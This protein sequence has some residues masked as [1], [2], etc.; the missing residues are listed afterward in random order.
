MKSCLID[1]RLFAGF[2]RMSQIY[3]DFTGNHWKA[4]G[5]YLEIHPSQ[6]CPEKQ[7]LPQVTTVLLSHS[8]N[9]TLAEEI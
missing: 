6:C 2:T 8:G 4:S 3:L 1:Q 5:R 7:D 9:L